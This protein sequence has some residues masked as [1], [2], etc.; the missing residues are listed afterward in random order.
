MNERSSRQPYAAGLDIRQG[1]V[2]IG[3]VSV[4]ANPDQRIGARLRLD[5]FAGDGVATLSLPLAPLELRELAGALRL[6]AD[7]AERARRGRAEAIS[8]SGT[9]VPRNAEPRGAD[10]DAIRR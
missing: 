5:V 1:G 9:P 4:F 7:H 10:D 3:A 6:A 2:G 8:T